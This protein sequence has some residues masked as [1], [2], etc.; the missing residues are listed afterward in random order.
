MS[1]INMNVRAGEM[2]R[3]MNEL[4]EEIERAQLE[5]AQIVEQ[6]E[7]AQIERA[8]E[9]ERVEQLERAIEKERESRTT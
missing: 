8:I 1:P 6:L 2:R 7:R 9:K 3:R 4:S 5:R